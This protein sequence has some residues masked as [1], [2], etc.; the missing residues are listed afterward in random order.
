MPATSCSNGHIYTFL[1]SVFIK[2][3][4]CI[5]MMAVPTGFGL[6]ILK[7]FGL[8]HVA[9]VEPEESICQEMCVAKLP[10]KPSKLYTD[11]F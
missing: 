1:H 8:S 4:D 9:V 7:D 6:H 11:N 5:E 3:V 10:A 2:S